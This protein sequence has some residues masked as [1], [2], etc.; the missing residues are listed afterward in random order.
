M[1]RRWFYWLLAVVFAVLVGTHFDQV[2]NL[3]STLLEGEW[4]WVLVAVGLQGLY[5]VTLTTLYH[6]AFDTVR[7]HSRIHELLPV[8]LSSVF[9]N[10]AAPSAGAS[11]I[12]LFANDAARR[13]QSAVRAS[14]GSLLVTV[15]NY[16]AFLLVL[17]A[18]LVYLSV[19]R[20][21]QIY[22]PFAAGILVLMLLA[23]VAL[24]SL[25][26][27]NPGGLRRML[28][29]VERTVNWIAVRFKRSAPLADGWA[30]KSATEFCEAARA[31]A[32]HPRR[33][34][35]T[36]GVALVMHI[37]NMASLYV[38][39]M[40]FHQVVNIGSLVAGFAMG[41]LFLNVSF[42]PQGIGT[43]EGAMAAAYSSLGVPTAKATVIALAFRGLAFWLPVI[44]GFFVFQWVRSLRNRA[45]AGAES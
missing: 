24:L 13:G 19:Q 32:T 41:I 45:A 9:L 21:L 30:E 20:H 34:G 39:F 1:K 42:T 7:V 14:A 37:V 8:T 33:L 15:S 40:A 44:V 18:G 29:G 31:V 11:G 4:R 16:S 26:L 25:G 27:W 22:Q 17:T 36:V 12:A 35:R 5:Y 3:A 2:Q 6:S 10:A 38:L 28:G 43:V 23:L